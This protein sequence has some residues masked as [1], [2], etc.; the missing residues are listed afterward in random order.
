VPYVPQLAQ[1]DC[2]AA[3]IAMVLALHGRPVP[4]EEVREITG[5]GRDGASAHGILQAARWFGL[6]ARG[7]KV[8]SPRDLARLPAGTVL[9]WRFQHFL[10]LDRVGRW[11]A[12]V[13]DPARG[14]RRLSW[15]ELDE[16]LTGVVLVLEPGEGLAAPGPTDRRRRRRRERRYLAAIGREW[17]LLARVVVTSL[18]LQGSALAVPIAT[19]LLVDR[20]VTGGERSL[21]TVITAGI[22]GLVGFHLLASLVRSHVF[23]HLRNRLDVRMTLEFLEH[24]VSLPYRYFQE[25]SAGDLLTRLNSHSAIREML[26]SGVL[27]TLLDGSLVVLYL[28]LLAVAHPGMATL[29]LGLAIARVVI[30]VAARVRQR[31]LMAQSLQ[32]EARSRGYQVE[33]LS[34]I[35]TLKAAGAEDRAVEHWTHLFVDVLN[36]A[37]A[38]GRL[39]ATVDALLEALRVASPLAVLVYGTTEVLAGRLTLGTMLALSALAA[40]FLM[41]VSQWIQTANQLQFLKSYL[42]RID[43]VID[44]EPETSR[45]EGAPVRRP[46]RLRGSIRLENVSFRYS[47]TA[48]PALEDVSLEVPAGAFIALVGPSGAGKSTLA[49]LLV[50]LYPPSEGRVL[51][52]GVDLAEIDL[53]SLR[54]QV[55]LVPQH[56]RLF[57]GS[58]RTNIALFDPALP[59]PKIAEAARRA[60]LHDEILAMPL[61]YET[62]LG[63][64]GGALSGGQRQRLVLARALVREP[65]ILV[66]DEATSS[67]DTI[68]ETRLQRELEGLRC[69]RI[70]IAHRLSTVRNADLLLVLDRGSLV[71]TG[72]HRELVARRGV[73]AAL[74]EAQLAGASA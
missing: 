31:E 2:G 46:L 50:G 73:Y 66:L 49:S 17:R 29:V 63:D 33:L 3:C 13:V 6:R 70:V 42:D 65:A 20:V 19:G 74:A 14:R 9:H 7:V 54:R 62:F 22:A 16:G 59:L 69:T 25:R 10:V 37:V 36:A 47:P 67:L 26:T 64:G 55:G 12:S 40:G 28:A 4:L 8:G 52:D 15:R 58:V 48:P 56:P 43:E 41:P 35:E 24:L 11:G 44:A 23:V 61:G 71:E 53:G 57:S 34:G 18:L 5:A 32:A 21:L 39:S 60:C 1:S 27:S 72:S 30:F 45:A 38:R 51:F 68:T